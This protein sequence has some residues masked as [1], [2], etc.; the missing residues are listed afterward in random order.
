MATIKELMEKPTRRWV[1][2]TY[3]FWAVRNVGFAGAAGPGTYKI[4]G[5]EG[6]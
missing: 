6:G 3:K 2:A 5:G 1:S 4:A